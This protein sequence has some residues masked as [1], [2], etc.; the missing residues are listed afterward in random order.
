M[1]RIVVAEDDDS[2]RRYLS[3]VLVAA[4]YEVIP[5]RDGDEALEQLAQ[6]HVDLL[7][8]DVMMPARS[9]YEVTQT[10]RQAGNMLPIL[11]VTA[12]ETPEDR[13][14]GFICGTDDYMVKPIDEQEMV[15]RI[16]ALLRR[17]RIAS[18]HRLKIGGM[19]LDYDTFTVEYGAEATE[20]PKKEFQLL[21]KLL[22]YPNKIFTKRQ[23]M[24]E[25]WDY[26]SFSDEHTIEVHIGRLRDRFKNIPE[27]EIVTAR[28]LGYK[29][30]RKDQ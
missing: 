29:A 8:L 15:L 12:R 24:D 5:A 18:E 21:F 1:F 23:L 7:A 11:M 9:G 19:T 4:G 22:S 20:L 26:D 2:T 3:D 27:F 10:L 6:H 17:S 28:G 25:I 13:R 16:A 14:K 30:V